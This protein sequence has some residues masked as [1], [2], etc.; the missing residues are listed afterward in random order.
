MAKVE[1]ATNPNIEW[2]G[3]TMPYTSLNGHMFTH[4]SKT[5]TTGLR[6]PK[7]EREDFLETCHTTLYEQHGTI[8]KE[9]VT[10]P[11][12][13]LENTEKLSKYLDISYEY[14][15]SMK[16]KRSKKKS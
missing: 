7:R 3:V 16:P 11:D 12:D 9:Y 13:L 4:F 2:K 5:G 6:L 1:I 15:Q 14:V 8:M 10:V